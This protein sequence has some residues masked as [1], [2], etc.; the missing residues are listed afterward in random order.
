MVFLSGLLELIRPNLLPPL[1]SLVPRFLAARSIASLT[2]DLHDAMGERER[3]AMGVL[4]VV[5]VAAR[6]LSP[7]RPADA[8]AA[9][10]GPCDPYARVRRRSRRRL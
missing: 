6:G 1:L 2:S 9:A 4:L 3:D 10:A 5:V 7:P 8:A